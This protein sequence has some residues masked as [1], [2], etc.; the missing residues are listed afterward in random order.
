M[1][2]NISII[3]LIDILVYA[4]IFGIIIYG[5]ILGYRSYDD[6]YELVKE[7]G[8]TEYLT[9][10]FLFICCIIFAVRAVRSYRNKNNKQLIFNIIMCLL[11]FFGTGEE[12]SWGQRI[13]NIQT[14]EFFLENNYQKEINLHNLKIGNI[15]LNI[16][17]FSKLMFVALLFYFVILD[18]LAWKSKKIRKLI[19]DFDVPLPK[20]HHTTI[21]IIQNILVTTIGLL[22]DSELNELSLAGILFLVFIS[23]AKRIMGISVTKTENPK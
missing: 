22:K 3:T 8:V 10:L 11:F 13:F 2:R 6:F 4:L 21:L 23:P 7:D 1:K 12:I 5:K 19:T 16:L 17:I 20:L 18:I 9:T 14:G 15:N